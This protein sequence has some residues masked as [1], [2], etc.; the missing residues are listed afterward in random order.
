MASCL[1]CDDRGGWHD[2]ANG[3][4]V[5]CPCAANV[6]KQLIATV[7]LPVRTRPVKCTQCGQRSDRLPHAKYCTRGDDP[8]GKNCHRYELIPVD[9][10][11]KEIVSEDLINNLRRHRI[12]LVWMEP[13]EKA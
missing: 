2:K 12:K 10:Y 1:A 6:G 3:Q 5:T 7:G 13:E 9:E 11:A 8:G 4:W